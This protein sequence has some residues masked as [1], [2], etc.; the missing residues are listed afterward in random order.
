MATKQMK[1]LD[2]LFSKEQ[3]KKRTSR[4]SDLRRPRR[5]R[6]VLATPRDAG[7]KVAQD[8]VETYRAEIAKIN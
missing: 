4:V 8:S 5:R 7:K 1:S 3:A 6:R 2:D